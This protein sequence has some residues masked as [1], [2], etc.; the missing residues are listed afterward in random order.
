MFFFS[1]NIAMKCNIKK[2]LLNVLN[3]VIITNSRTC[4]PLSCRAVVGEGVARLLHLHLAPAKVAVAAAGGGAHVM[5]VTE[6]FPA[7]NWFTCREQVL[8]RG[9][10]WQYD[11]NEG[12]SGRSGRVSSPFG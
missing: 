1:K 7:P 6:C 3:H 9:K 12:A 4:L 11:P 8:R 5:V 2:I 10:A